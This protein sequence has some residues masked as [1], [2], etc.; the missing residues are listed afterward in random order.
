MWYNFRIYDSENAFICG[1]I[2]NIWVLAKYAI[3]YAMAGP[4][5]V[6]GPG[7]TLPSP[8]MGLWTNVSYALPVLY[9]RDSIVIVAPISGIAEH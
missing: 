7:K 2:C 6:T 4:P 5:N 3:A 9:T 1:K 8:S